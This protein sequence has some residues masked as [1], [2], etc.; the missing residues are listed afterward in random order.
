MK[1]FIRSLVITLTLFLMT[2]GHAQFWNYKKVTGNGNLTTK[3]IRHLH[4]TTSNPWAL[5]T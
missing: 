4:M 5:W 3:T 1:S 2:V